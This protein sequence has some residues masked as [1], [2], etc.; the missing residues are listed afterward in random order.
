MQNQAAIIYF[1]DSLKVMFKN[2][3]NLFIEYYAF[4]NFSNPSAYFVGENSI[5]SYSAIFLDENWSSLSIS[6]TSSSFSDLQRITPPILRFLL[7]EQTNFI[8]NNTYLNI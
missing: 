1:I 4:I 3:T 6:L 2:T 7:P 8:K 5:I